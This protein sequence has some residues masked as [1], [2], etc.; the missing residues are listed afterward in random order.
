MS[1]HHGGTGSGSGSGNGSD[2]SEP[3]DPTDPTANEPTPEPKEPTSEPKEPTSEP[4]EPTSEPESTPAPTPVSGSGGIALPLPVMPAEYAL[5]VHYSIT[6][7]GNTAHYLTS[8]KYNLNAQP[9]YRE[10]DLINGRLSAST[11]ELP[12]S[13]KAAYRYNAINEESSLGSSLPALTASRLS[14]AS[15]RISWPS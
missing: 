6:T 1:H 4:K 9:Q 8:R 15:P 3:A 13:K 10:D 5:N 14:T 11:I 7:E 2:S 12:T